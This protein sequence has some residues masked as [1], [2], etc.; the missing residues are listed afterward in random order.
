MK[1]ALKEVTTIDGFEA[2]RNHYLEKR[3]DLFAE[4]FSKQFIY[5]LKV[6]KKCGPAEFYEIARA[7]HKNLEKEPGVLSRMGEAAFFQILDN[8]NAEL[9]EVAIQYFRVKD[10]E[11]HGTKS[12]YWN[13]ETSGST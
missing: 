6:L 8:E 7:L 4:E 11:E 13:F 10:F 9:C 1:K 3:V 12:M 2:I 5:F